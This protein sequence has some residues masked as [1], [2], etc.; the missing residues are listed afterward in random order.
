MCEKA[1]V[2]YKEAERRDFFIELFCHSNLLSSRSVEWLVIGPHDLIQRSIL[3]S[4][5]SK[6]EVF[7]FLISRAIFGKFFVLARGL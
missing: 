1:R 2:K 7:I 5:S 4:I 6:S 3:S